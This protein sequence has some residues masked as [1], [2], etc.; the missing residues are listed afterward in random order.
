[1]KQAGGENPDRCCEFVMRGLAF[2]RMDMDGRMGGCGW[3]GGE[4]MVP[5]VQAR[6]S[7]S[8]SCGPWATGGES[9]LWWNRD[10]G[11]WGNDVPLPHQLTAARDRWLL[12]LAPT[13]AGDCTER[14]ID[15]DEMR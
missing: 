9:G 6:G 1:M 8:S 4:D 10:P 11:E 15:R 14:A 3:I 5:A 12:V 7:S 13:M 2:A